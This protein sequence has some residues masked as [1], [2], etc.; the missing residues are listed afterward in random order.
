MKCEDYIFNHD[1]IAANKPGMTEQMWLYCKS[2]GKCLRKQLLFYLDAPSLMSSDKL[3]NCCD[4]CKPL[5]GCQDCSCCN[6]VTRPLPYITP[7]C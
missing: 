1:I 5:S 4:V 7:G 2:T 6:A 3:H